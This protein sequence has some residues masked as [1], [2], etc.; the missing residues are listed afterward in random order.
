MLG[1]SEM[2]YGRAISIV[3]LVLVILIVGMS[4]L[5]EYET[6]LPLN[7]TVSSELEND[8]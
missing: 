2:I 4:K 3:A 6:S 8:K 7:T 5:Y 1:L